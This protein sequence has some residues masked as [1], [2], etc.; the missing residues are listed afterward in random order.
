M[1]H[2]G[3]HAWSDYARN[4]VDADTRQSMA[5]HLAECSTCRRRLATLDRV[6]S[7][8]RDEAVHQVPESVSRAAYAV[9]QAP[10]PSP[11]LPKL[12]ARLV[13][14]SGVGLAAADARTVGADTRR[15]VFEGEG[16]RLELHMRQ[17]FDTPRMSMAG[18]VQHL[19]S[20][21]SQQ[22]QLPIYLASR[23][24]IVARTVCNQFGEF[25]LDFQPRPG[26]KLGLALSESAAPLEIGIGRLATGAEWRRQ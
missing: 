3:I 24:K 14:D 13:F 23:R 12:V 9:F 10:V 2:Y 26:L 7:T 18:Q 21:S 20:T 11:S 17:E 8:A 1:N 5:S 16:Y 15:L 25:L 4:L 22:P 19:N 6:I